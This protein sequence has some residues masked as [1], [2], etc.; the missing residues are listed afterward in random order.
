MFVV[1]GALGLGGWAYASLV[2]DATQTALQA[3]TQ[4]GALGGVAFVLAY[5]TATLFLLPSIPWPLAAGFLYGFECGIVLTWLAEMLGATGG[6]ALGRSLL[7][8]RVERWLSTNERMQAIDLAFTGEG[9]RLATL[10]RLSPA[11]PFGALSYTLSMTGIRPLAY[12][13]ANAIG[14][15][16]SC[17][18]LV[19]VGTRLPHLQSIWTG[20]V[21]LGGAEPLATWGGLVVTVVAGWMLAR[22]ARQALTD[23]TERAQ[24]VGHR[25]I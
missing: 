10:L 11:L 19:W 25:G 20:D 18:A 22:L 12:V 6:F 15:T 4:W 13:A 14:V 16:P 1:V 7:R 17:L 3:I 2:D 24:P 5:A 8:S 21:G 23:A 9:F